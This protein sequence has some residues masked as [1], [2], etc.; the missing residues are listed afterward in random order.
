[1]FFH[2]SCV[3]PKRKVNLDLG[4]GFRVSMY[5][6]DPWNHCKNTP[7]IVQNGLKGSCRPAGGKV[8]HRTVIILTA[9]ILTVTILTVTIFLRD[10]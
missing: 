6:I 8:L 7:K 4:F 1:M 10:S 2:I 3:F 9:T 5:H